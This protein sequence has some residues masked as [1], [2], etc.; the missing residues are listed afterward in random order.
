MILGLGLGPQGLEH[1]VR[2]HLGNHRKR[3]KSVKLFVTLSIRDV[4][5]LRHR[6]R[7]DP[8]EKKTYGF[9]ILSSRQYQIRPWA[10][11]REG[12]GKRTSKDAL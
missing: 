10:M 6:Y 7:T 8:V 11:S 5:F 4:L 1:E 9:S 3:L 12:G 2:A